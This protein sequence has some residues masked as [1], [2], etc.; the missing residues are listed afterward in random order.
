MY[1]LA[2][3]LGAARQSYTGA[4]EIMDETPPKTSET[5]KLVA[6]ARAASDQGDSVL[7]HQLLTRAEA[8]LRLDDLDAIVDLWSAIALAWLGDFEPDER[9]RR[10]TYYLELLGE[11]GNLPAQEML[12]INYLEGANGVDRS[13]EKFLYWSERAMGSGSELAREEREKFEAEKADRGPP[14]MH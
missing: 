10:S 13:E 14:Q 6:D 9:G 8:V 3:A 5:A 1:S 2:A 4:S 7:C 11:A 12:M